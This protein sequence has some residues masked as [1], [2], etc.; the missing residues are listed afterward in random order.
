MK[1]HP[2]LMKVHPHNLEVEQ[3]VI[4][5][6]FINP[7]CIPKVQKALDPDDFYREAHQ[8]IAR[9][10]FELRGKA[11]FVTVSDLLK[12]K[13]LLE[14]CGGA[15]YLVGLVEG[16]S[17]SAGI[18]YHAE[19]IKELSKRRK[20]IENCMAGA[21]KAFGLTNEI[22]GILSNLKSGIREM[23]SDRKGDFRS[24]QELVKAVFQDIKTRSESGNRFV[25]VKTGFEN[26]DLY[27]NGLEPKTTNYLIARPS[28]G[29]TALA[30]NIADFVACN[31]PGKVIFFSLESGD[32]PLT[33]RR[34]STHSGVF[35]SRL[36]TGDI[37]DDQWQNLIQSASVLREENL[38]IIDRAK[39]KTVENLVSIA[40]TLAMDSPLSLIVIDHIQRMKSEGKF[41]NRHLELSYI[42][43]EISSLAN[44]LNIPILILCQL[45]RE[46]EKRKDQ[47][48]R[49]SDMKESGDLEANADSVWGI[50]RKDKEDEYAHLEGLKGR[51]TGTWRTWLKFDG[52]IQKFS[53]CKDPDYEAEGQ[54]ISNGKL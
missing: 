42:S 12:A 20:I 23:Q 34:L 10:F 9:A 46:V 22:D 26:I 3:A 44:E 18:E 28:M 53:D 49:L 27:M 37:R 38:I 1:S 51:D 39:Y 25:G 19:I 40:E 13:G 6:M 21:E 30:L 14:K 54:K 2:P 31:Y 4:G 33:R 43:E 8:H 24:N 41:N 29:K 5:G 48:P 47:R 52:S 15:D 45:N 11:D 35:L 50:Y 17:T 36:R 32:K 7:K 16:V